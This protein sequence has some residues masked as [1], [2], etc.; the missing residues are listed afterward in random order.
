VSVDPVTLGITLA[1]NAAQMA[2]SASKKIEGPRLTDLSVSTADYGTPLPQFYGTK[3]LECMC[4]YA[5]EIRE[6]KHRNKTKNGKYD[7]YSYFGTWASLIADN[8]IDGV[9]KLWLDRHLVS[10]STGTGG[11]VEQLTGGNWRTYLGTETQEP[12]P[13]LLAKIEAKEGPGT[14]PAYLGISYMVFEEIPLQVFGNRMPQVSCEASRNAQP[15]YPYEQHPT[16]MSPTSM[17]SSGGSWMAIGA[18]GVATTIEWW[19]LPTRTLVGYTS[20]ID[21]GAGIVTNIDQGNDGTAYFI[22]QYDEA[23]NAHSA[24]YVVEP[25]GGASKTFVGGPWFSGPTRVFDTSAGRFV[26]S[27]TDHSQTSNGYL[28]FGRL[29]AT[30]GLGNARDFCM[31]AGENIYGLFLPSSSNWLVISPLAGDSPVS[32]IVAVGHVVRGSPGDAAIAY[33]ESENHFAVF[34]DGY[35]YAIDAATGTIKSSVASSP[36]LLNV[37][38]KT[39]SAIKFWSSFSE[40]SLIDGSVLD[41]VD[42]STFVSE[43]T[44]SSEKFYDRSSDAIITHP[45]FQPHLTWRFMNRKSGGGWTL[46]QICADVADQCGMRPSD[47]NFTDLDQNVPGYTWTQG[48]GKDVIGA[49]LDLHDSDIRPHGFIQEGLK[50]GQPLVGNVITTDWMVNENSGDRASSTPL[51]TAPM[52]AETDLP[53]R[54]RATFADPSIEEQPNNAA[55]QRNAASVATNREQSFDLTTLNEDPAV[56]Q[57]LLERALRRYWVGSTKPAFLLTPLE[58]RLEPADVRMVRFEDGELLRCR[59]TKI[60]IRANRTI[61]TEWEVDGETQVNPPS[62]ELDNASPLNRVFSTPGAFT[63]GRTPDVIPVPVQTKGF[64]FDTPL[65]S[66]AHDQSAPFLYDAASPYSDAAM[67]LG[68]LA[69]HADDNSADAVYDIGWDSF[70]SGE[71]TVWGNCGNT[72]PSALTEI[73][74]EGSHLDVTILGGG[75]LSSVSEDAL[76]NDS[77]LNLAL[78][79][80][81][82]IQFRDAVETGTN[83]WRIGGFVRGARNTEYAVAG[84]AAGET[85]LLIG[86][87]VHK[88]TIGASEIG[89]TDYYKFSSIGFD[90][91]VTGPTITI[92]FAANAHRPPAPAHLELS[93][94]AITGDWTISWIRRTRIGGGSVNGQDVPLGETSEAYRIK[95]MN[96]AV[97]VATYNVTSPTMVYSNAEQ[98]VDW[99]SAQT[100]LTVEVCQMSTA[101]SL[102][103]FSSS[104]SA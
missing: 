45:Q 6:V 50:R 86:S 81:E 48:A 22:G 46:G 91:S 83:I 2:M 95:V 62:W 78:V 96:G 44:G 47:Y 56:I 65:L 23:G 33:V 59:A 64:V 26:F 42:P 20:G 13:R 104:A 16:G 100:H 92:P 31:D 19:D 67:W 80:N 17:F 35:F 1:L 82:L 52:T 60:V 38:R 93:R 34:A 72:L 66:D 87:H 39:P 73:M 61:Q 5:E 7:E 71:L 89:D 69:W 40:V 75:S 43:D 53:L 11:T 4:I 51:Y 9:L 98:T 21:S 74:D 12:D 10:D 77:T 102:E 15:V 25:M 58:I 99:G 37:P 49:L 94:N 30:P 55:A 68:A 41:S 36:D 101:L 3:R 8:E 90:S 88:R 70:G 14:C 79:G 29:I 27:G 28:D 85:F 24:I 76:L 84:H 97:V 32:Q 63:Y 18:A 54:V 103:G 57:P